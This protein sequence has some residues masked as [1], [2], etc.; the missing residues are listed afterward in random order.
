MKEQLVT[1]PHPETEEVQRS[2]Y[3][4]LKGLISINENAPWTQVVFRHTRDDM[5]IKILYSPHTDNWRD[6]GQITVDIT[7]D[8][9]WV[10]ET[11]PQRLKNY[12]I[13]IFKFNEDGT[14][15]GE[16]CVK[17]PIAG[18]TINFKLP[19]TA[20]GAKKRNQDGIKIVDFV[21]NLLHPE[22]ASPASANENLTTIRI[23]LS[24]KRNIINR[25]LIG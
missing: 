2:P 10:G 16:N 17:E 4:E 3:E 20:E 11:G 14:I 23:P 19:R 5:D 13:G 25:G 22:Q 18:N 7:G 15:Q 21:K 9:L 24:T 1:S 8:V 12:P 6:Q